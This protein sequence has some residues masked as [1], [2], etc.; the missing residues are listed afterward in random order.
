M[1]PSL[2]PMDMVVGIMYFMNRRYT[3]TT[4]QFNPSGTFPVWKSK[5][6]KAY[7]FLQQSQKK[8]CKKLW[9]WYAWSNRIVKQVHDY[10]LWDGV[11]RFSCSILNAQEIN[12][13]GARIGALYIGVPVEL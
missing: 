2:D 5:I 11:E 7:Q 9:M 6:Q 4:K 13:I 8:V 12:R 1:Y 10:W 3:V